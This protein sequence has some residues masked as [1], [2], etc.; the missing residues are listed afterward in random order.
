VIG[1]DLAWSPKNATGLA[2]ATVT[3]ERVEVHTTALAY[4]LND[5]VEFVRDH[6]SV[7][8]TIAIDA[9]TVVPNETGM[10]PVER[11]LQSDPEL[12]RAHAAPYPANRQLL[13][14]CNGGRPRGEEL[15]ELL[16][17]E[18]QVTEVG[19]PPAHHCG[20]FAIEVFPL[21]AMPR[22]FGVLGVPVYK[23]KGSR[24]WPQ[25]QAGLSS[26]IERLRQLQ[27]PELDFSS[28]LRMDG[29]IGKKFKAIED[30]VDAVLCAYIAALA[31][32][33]EVECVGTL[34]EGYITLPRPRATT[35][36]RVKEKLRT[37]LGSRFSEALLV[38]TDIHRCQPRKGTQIPYMA[39]ILAV[40]AIALEFGATE[41]EAIAALLHDAVEDAP[42]EL[43]PN[44]GEWAR[45]LIAF[46]FGRNV[47]DIVEANTDT[48]VKPKPAWRVRKEQYI[49]SIAH[50][51]SSVL[52]VSAADKLH[53]ARA[54]LADYREVGAEVFTRFNEEAGQAGTLGYYRGLVTASPRGLL[55]SGIG[56]FSACFVS[57][58]AP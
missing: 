37:P 29:Q 42:E 26:Y 58:S 56:E 12:Q 32:L 40:A 21:A 17:R 22:L 45:R 20:R 46:K 51:S 19:C 49:T 15:V 41:D 25:C 31:W 27:R 28:E 4:S 36:G 7:P 48:D 24:T 3:G 39:H 10:R 43:G 8:I 13:G 55:H 33:G 14:K 34:D 18:L 44:E 57:L 47:L 2:A 16:K 38:A 6:S 1:I 35:E 52:L 50:K 11:I 9:P 54:I 53:N 5:I 23:K 30:R